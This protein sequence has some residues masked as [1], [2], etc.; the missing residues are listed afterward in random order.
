MAIQA[1]KPKILVVVSNNKKGA[2]RALSLSITRNYLFTGSFDDGELNVFDLDKP[3]R[4]KYAKLNATLMGKDKVRSVC[5]SSKRNEIMCGTADGAITFWNAARGKS[6]CIN[7]PIQM[8]FKALTTKLPNWNIWKT[9]NSSSPPAKANQSKYGSSQN[10]G[11][12]PISSTRSRREE[13]N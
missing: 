7:H 11:R 1:E 3:G 13:R 6:I 8:S 9:R 5:W 10:N 12:T 4:E 2:I